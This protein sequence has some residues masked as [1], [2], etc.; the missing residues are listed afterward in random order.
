L[1]VIGCIVEF[2]FVAD[3]DNAPLKIKGCDGISKRCVNCQSA[4]AKLGSLEF[5]NPSSK[6]IV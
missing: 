6:N 3:G 4:A 2:V 1:F 5:D